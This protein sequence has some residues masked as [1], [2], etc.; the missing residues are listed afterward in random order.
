M[1]TYLSDQTSGGTSAVGIR[2]DLADMITRISPT[3]TPVYTALKKETVKNALYEWQVQELAAASASNAIEE[4]ADAAA[5][6]HV[7]T[8]RVSNR[9][10]ISA[11][12]GQVSGTLDAVDTAGRTRETAYQKMLKGLELR[13]DI[14][15]TILT[16]QVSAAGVSGSSARTT[17]TLA[18]Y[19]S[20][21]SADTQDQTSMNTAGAT[22]APADAAATG[23]NFGAYDLDS[24][25]GANI[26]T[27][28]TARALALSLIDEQMQEAFTDGGQ[29]NIMVV[30]PKNK[31]TFSD[32]GLASTSVVDNQINQ[33]AAKPASVVGAVSVYL[34]DFGQ[35]D[36]VVDR[37]APDSALYLL[38]TNYA[39]VVNLPGRNFKV[40]DLAKTG[41]STK[42]QIICEWGVKVLAPKAHAAIY[43]L[44]G[45]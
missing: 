44:S 33:T 10:Q 5:A 3:E 38:D 6:S 14:E 45:S 32:L 4:G 41:D 13:R 1:A 17:G 7:P 18:A 25:A 43:D 8:S 27:T 11:K 35:L 26:P 34:T 20:N 30:S 29:P 42:F 19:I 9:T 28:G 12:Y 37:F 16:P 39:S 24:D 31:A 23:Y 15:K 36:V 40:E 2:E 21:F 22:A